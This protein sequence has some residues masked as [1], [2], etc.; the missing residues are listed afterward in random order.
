MSPPPLS[1]RGSQFLSTAV[2]TDDHLNGR[3]YITLDV[4]QMFNWE[5]FFPQKAADNF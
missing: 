3:Y 4:K 5:H 1:L 2:L